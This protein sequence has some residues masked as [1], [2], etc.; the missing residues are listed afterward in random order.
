ML[1][2]FFVELVKFVNLATNCTFTV[3]GV[4]NDAE[5]AQFDSRD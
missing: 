4:R 2:R 1:P 3:S 5:N